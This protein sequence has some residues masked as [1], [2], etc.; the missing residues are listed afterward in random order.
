MIQVD[1]LQ[2]QTYTIS[3]NVFQYAVPGDFVADFPTQLSRYIS[4]HPSVENGDTIFSM[5]KTLLALWERY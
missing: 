1:Y 4:R 5:F 2:E 3:K